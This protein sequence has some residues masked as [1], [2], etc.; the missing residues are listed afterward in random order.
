[1][2]AAAPVHCHLSS[3]VPV[4]SHV[5]MLSHICNYLLSME[6]ADSTKTC[7]KMINDDNQVTFNEK[8]I[9]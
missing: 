7:N 4:T 1:M 3:P 9:E 2:G 6:F 8:K 5:R